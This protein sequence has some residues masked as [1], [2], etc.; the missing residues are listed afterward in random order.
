MFVPWPAWMGSL[1]SSLKAG[2]A[3]VYHHSQLLLVEM[4]VSLTFSLDWPVTV[5]PISASQEARI[6]GVRQHTSWFLC[7]VGRVF[8]CF[9]TG[10]HYVAQAG[11]GLAFRSSTSQ[12]LGMHHTLIEIGF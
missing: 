5:I 8:V 4:G 1:Y 9:E 11:L 12:T 10:S 3:G 7:F 6:S 2:M